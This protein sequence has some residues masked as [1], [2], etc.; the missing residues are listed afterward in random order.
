MGGVKLQALGRPLRLHAKQAVGATGS[1]VTSHNQR[2]VS[3]CVIGS[4]GVWGMGGRLNGH[5]FRSITKRGGAKRVWHPS[6]GTPDRVPLQ[7]WGN[8]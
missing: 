6:G 1:R 2:G 7:G 4:S 5:G 3:A 8:Q